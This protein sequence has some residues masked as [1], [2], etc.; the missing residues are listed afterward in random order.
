MRIR[1]TPVDVVSNDI[2][3]L[4]TLIGRRITFVDRFGL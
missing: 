4:P 1:F 2:L 3:N